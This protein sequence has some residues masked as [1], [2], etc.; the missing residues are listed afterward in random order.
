LDNGLYTDIAVISAF[1]LE[2]F[3]LLQC[4][5]SHHMPLQALE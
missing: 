3:H 1:A 2:T 4:G 5:I